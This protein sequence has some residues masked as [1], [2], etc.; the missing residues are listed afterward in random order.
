VS[1]DE[2]IARIE[3]LGT[4]FAREMEPLVDEQEIRNL[5]ARYMGKKGQVSQ[6]MKQ[7]G[8]VPAE[9]R[10]TV[11]E[12]FNRIKDHITEAVVAKLHALDNAAQVADLGRVVDV[13]LP[14]RHPRVG[15]G[16]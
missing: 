12:A 14:G 6:L 13:S 3:D 1:A 16:K 9:A 2:L 15:K 7:M 10:R 4:Q 11:G 5:Q 8:E